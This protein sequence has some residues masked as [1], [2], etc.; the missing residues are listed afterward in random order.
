[1]T[2]SRSKLVNQLIK[3][4]K[5]MNAT[6]KAFG[7]LL[8]LSI[9]SIGIPTLSAQNLDVDHNATDVAKFKS[10]TGTTRVNLDGSYNIGGSEKRAFIETA[11]T[12]LRL[13]TSNNNT[14]GQIRF[15]TSS[16]GTST[17]QM[18][19]TNNGNV[20]IGTTIPSRRLTVESVST[21]PM[22]IRTT[23][24]DNWSSIYTLNGYIGYWGA[25]NGTYDMD[26]GTGGGNTTGK[27]T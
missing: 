24:A 14:G 16:T 7:L 1:M 15:A 8:F 18:T 4:L 11:N 25:V 20:G 2:R 21:N 17:D 23:V 10:T 3:K 6:T 9:I 5:N 22:Q 12:T 27:L 13:S 19:I 26:F